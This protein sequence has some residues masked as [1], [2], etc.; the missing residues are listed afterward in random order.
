MDDVILCLSDSSGHDSKLVLEIFQFDCKQNEF[1]FDFIFKLL[2]NVVSHSNRADAA[3]RGQRL[4]NKK[5]LL[6][7]Y[8]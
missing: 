5:L 6:N 3:C 4:R 7:C 2:H 1:H 8:V